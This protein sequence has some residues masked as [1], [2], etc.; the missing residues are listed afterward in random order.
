[1]VSLYIENRYIELDKDVQF[2]INKTF[3][4]ITNPTSIIN[5]W[6]KTVSIPFTDKN[7]ETFGH[8]YN[9]DRITLHDE[10]LTTGLYFD[11]LKK[12]D[13]R[14]EWDSAV[15]MMGYAKMTS[16]TKTNGT[17]RYN[18]TLN[19][20]LG[21]VFQEMKKITFDSSAYTGEDKDK[22]WIDGKNWFEKTMN[23]S[24]FANDLNNGC[25]QT[26][27]FYSETPTKNNC[28]GF[29][30]NNSKNKN[31]DYTSVN[32]YD[33]STNSIQSFVDILAKTE[34]ETKNKISPNEVIPDGMLPREIGEYRSYLQH[35]FI[36]WHQLFYIFKDKFEQI[37]DYKINL[38]PYWFNIYNPYW[39]KLIL[40]LKQLNNDNESETSM[41]YNTKLETKLAPEYKQRVWST[42]NYDYPYYDPSLSE[43]NKDFDVDWSNKD[44]GISWLLQLYKY[45][46]EGDTNDSYIDNTDI[47]MPTILKLN[48]KPSINATLNFYISFY[49]RHQSGKGYKAKC[50]DVAIAPYEYMDFHLK[51]NYIELSTKRQIS[52]ITK[53]YVIVGQNSRVTDIP[54]DVT[55]IETGYSFIKDGLAFEN[56]TFEEGSN[57]ISQIKFPIYIS[58]NFADDLGPDVDLSNVGVEIL[59]NANWNTIGNNLLLWSDKAVRDVYAQYWP[60]WLDTVSVNDE[61]TEGTN[62]Y[63]KPTFSINYFKNKRS[64]ADINLEDLWFGGNIFEEI[65]K[66][67]KMYKI[68]I[69]VDEQNKTIDFLQ[70]KT[71]F[72]KYNILDWTDKLDLSKDFNIQPISFQN[73]Y[74]LFNYEND[75]SDLNKEYKTKFGVNYGEKKINT[76]YLFNE[77]TKELF[78]KI[79]TSINTTP[80]VNSWENLYTENK[81][82]YLFP[83]EIYVADGNNNESIDI[84]GKYFFYNRLENFDTSETLNLRSVCITDDTEFQKINNLYCYSQRFNSGYYYNIEKYPLCTTVEGDNCCLFNIPSTVYT[85]DKTLFDNKT[86]IYTNFWQNYLDERYNIN[87]KIVTCYLN[88]TPIDFCNFKFNNFIKIN[89]QLY[90]VNKI[91]DYDIISNSP[92]KVDLITV[93][94]L[95]G[96]TK[97]NYNFGFLEVFNQHKQ[98]WDN[99]FDYIYLD[100]NETETIYISSTSDVTFTFDPEVFPVLTINGERETGVIPAGIQ[101][102]V[103]FHNIETNSLG[104]V[105]FFNEDG[106]SIIIDVKTEIN[107]KF[108]VYDTDKTV[109]SSTDKVELQNTNPLTK[110][111]YIT[112]PNVDVSWNDNGTNLQNLTINGNTGSGS[113]PKGTMVPVVFTMINEE[114]GTSDSAIYGE[115]KFYTPQKTVTIDVSLVWNEIFTIY[116]WDGE[117]WDEDVDYIKLTQSDPIKTIYLSANDTVE[118]SDVSGDLQSLYLSTDQDSEDWGSYTKGSGTIYPP[119]NMKPVHFRMDKEGQQGT[120]SGK[121]LF[122]N[123]R[124]EWFIDVELNGD[125]PPMLIYTED[126]NLVSDWETLTLAGQETQSLTVYVTSDTDVD[127]SIHQY[128][129]SLTDVQINGSDAIELYQGYDTVTIKAGTKV[130]LTIT[131]VFGGEDFNLEMYLNNGTISRVF[132]IDCV[133]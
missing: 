6:S 34:F 64:G 110:T 94:D 55:K 46:N 22:Y 82:I 76:N 77:E 107:T 35:P 70:S 12:L 65:L 18:V 59:F 133:W 69:N 115:I 31:F 112:S 32:T 78:S 29:F 116:R 105:T 56:M 73:K 11:P 129:G 25:W 88:I 124:H 24:I 57:V 106:Q 95:N 53:K 4:D 9:P 80:Y 118:W 102:P 15:L 113:I 60:V 36:Y 75:E 52:I 43:Y 5:D 40:T 10:G 92:T 23:I 26:E 84:S 71:Y 114:D 33:G 47:Y 128:S 87:N 86:D 42:Y 111:L 99:H 19:G 72:K 21:K 14:L 121:V 81:I 91:Y 63:I 98:L 127:V 1:M 108:T 45:P 120:D 50:L 38:D 126:N 51:F 101:V 28:V 58:K 74:V 37:S 61:I 68:L 39:S 66:Y 17:G 8:I 131:T 3:E 67:C 109:W 16:V 41:V 83:S 117:V 125:V 119:S 89:N 13:F 49:S 62:T 123:G 122:F 20:E 132:Y 130:P 100:G 96:Y 44:S 7:N 97:D 54:A 2:A 79:K 85:S 93:Q 48:E 90:F 30:P 27:P 104:T 103:T